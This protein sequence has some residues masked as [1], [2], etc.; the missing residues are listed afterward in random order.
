[1]V[2]FILASIVIVIVFFILIVGIVSVAQSDKTVEVASNSVLKI[3]LN[4]SIPERTPN[5]PFSGLSFLGF[6]SDKSIG[7]NDILADIKKA[8]TDNS[9]KGIYLDE[10]YL[11]AGQATIEEIRNTLID[12]KKSGKFIIAYSEIYTQ[13]FYYLASVA[14]KVL[15]QMLPF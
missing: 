12:F 11:P 4:T 8:K 9:I 3:V 7:L 2:G 10:S 13:S 1:M 14:D 6:D 15:A 5:N